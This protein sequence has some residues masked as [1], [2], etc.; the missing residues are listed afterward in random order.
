MDHAF[1]PTRISYCTKEIFT[2]NVDREKYSVFHCVKT[3][4][5]HSDL[6]VVTLI[7]GSLIR[8]TFILRVSNIGTPSL[9]ST[10][11]GDEI[12]IL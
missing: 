12:L 6:K 5:F 8:A 11:I 10:L 2:E 7:Y 4:D 1:I 9:L 3:F